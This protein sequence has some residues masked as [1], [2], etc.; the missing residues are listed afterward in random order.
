M[1][2]DI[3]LRELKFKGIRSRGPGGQHVNK[4]A[5]KIE[6]KFQIETSEALT[7]NEKERLLKKLRSRISQDG[8]IGLQ[9]GETRSQHRNKSIAIARL[10]TLLNENLKVAKARK[11]TKPSKSAVERRLKVKKEQA[12]KKSARKPPSI[13]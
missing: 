6:L 1:E 2:I 9:C 3:L 11:K 12:K 8:W 4:T 13:D 5:S 7:N 10:L